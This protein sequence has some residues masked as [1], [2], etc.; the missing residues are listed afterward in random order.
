LVLACGCSDLSAHGRE[1]GEEEYMRSWPGATRGSRLTRHAKV[2]KDVLMLSNDVL[3]LSKDVLMQGCADARQGCARLPRLLKLPHWASAL[4]LWFMFECCSVQFN[5]Y[6]F[7]GETPVL[8]TVYPPQILER[9]VG[10]ISEK[11]KHFL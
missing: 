2:S 3:M 11:K 1:R 4:L 5:S 10:R 6:L 7:L 8:G 9:F